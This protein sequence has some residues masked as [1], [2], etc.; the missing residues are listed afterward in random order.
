MRVV[1]HGL[2][3]LH[4]SARGW[5]R[6]ELWAELDFGR[7]QSKPEPVELGGER[8]Q[9]KPFGLRGRTDWLVSEG[10][11][12]HLGPLKLLPPALL[13][14]RSALLHQVEPEVAV[15]RAR[16]VLGAVFVS[17]PDVVCSRLD[18]HADLQ[19]IA[20]RLEWL[21]R[22][23]SRANQARMFQRVEPDGERILSGFT[24]GRGGLL[25]RLYDKTLEQR[26]KGKA[27]R[28]DLW[29]QADSSRPVWRLEFQLR[30]EVLKGFG[31]RSP[32]EVVACRQ[33]L[34]RYCVRR[35]LSLRRKGE[36]SDRSRWPVLG[37]W[38]ELGRLRFGDYQGVQRR[39]LP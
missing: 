14:V 26:E 13:E 11:Q 12:L 19:D 37:W 24:F 8:F 28:A 4:L 16:G 9:T 15:A 21:E 25:A 1:G 10:F 7:S 5:V 6:S 23:V 34:W 2:D 35:W 32:E 29:P 38:W 20:P 30:R 31:V 36:H 18:L 39:Q 27:W 22:F 17:E 3:A 33:D